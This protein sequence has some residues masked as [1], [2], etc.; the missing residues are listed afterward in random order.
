[1]PSLA[2][3]PEKLVLS[4]SPAPLP[5]NWQFMVNPRSGWNPPSRDG[6]ALD[7]GQSASV[8]AVKSQDE[9]TTHGFNKLLMSILSRAKDQNLWGSTMPVTA[10]AMN[11]SS[12][13]AKSNTISLQLPTKPASNFG[14]SLAFPPHGLT[15]DDTPNAVFLEPGQGRRLYVREQP[16]AVSSLSYGWYVD[17]NTRLETSA[18][19]RGYD[20][21]TFW[22][23]VFDVCPRDARNVQ[24]GASLAQ[25][26]KAAIATG[27]PTSGTL[28]AISAAITANP[29]QGYGL[30][31]SSERVVVLNDEANEY[32]PSG[33]SKMSRSQ[34]LQQEDQAAQWNYRKFN[35][36]LLSNTY[37]VAGL[38]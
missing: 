30:F 36:A 3:L 17:A 5:R 10:I 4:V 35:P 28:A 20:R 37:G 26:L 38:A 14:T 24:D 7:L 25:R 34:W 2:G 32:G 19:S 12:L 11:G 1:M 18:A 29:Q 27:V 21:F 9:P 31:W 33:L 23:S 13:V 15:A 16:T 8:F 6:I 22:L